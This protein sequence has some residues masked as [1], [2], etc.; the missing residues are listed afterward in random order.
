MLCDTWTIAITIIFFAYSR[1]AI[2]Y[3]WTAPMAHTIFSY[4]Q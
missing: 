2:Y 1:A 3:L 4:V